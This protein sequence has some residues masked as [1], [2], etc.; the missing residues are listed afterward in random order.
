M[1]AEDK[2]SGADKIGGS[3]AN[4][5]SGPQDVNQAENTDSSKDKGLDN[6]K[7]KAAIENLFKAIAEL[8]KAI[9][10][11]E[12][13]K[14]GEEGKPGGAEPGGGQGGGKPGGAQQGG[15]Q[16]TGKPGGAQEDGSQG[17]HGGGGSC[18][19]DGG[20][21]PSGTEGG[22]GAGKPSEAGGGGSKGGK[23]D[24]AGSDKK[25]GG[26]VT[27][28][29]STIDLGDGNKVQV[30]G[31]DGTLAKN[32]EGWAKEHP[33]LKAD[34]QKSAAAN[35]GTLNVTVQDLPEG[36][37]GNAPGGGESGAGGGKGSVNIDPSAKDNLFCFSHEVKHLFGY[38]HNNKQ[39][40]AEMK[41]AVEKTVEGSEMSTQNVPQ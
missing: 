33:E 40:E 38:D 19:K 27:G 12:G 15:G 36:V 18:E 13:G 17:K 5:T 9:L 25:G 10:G 37:A 24:T 32:I 41:A 39:D 16:S 31:D 7:L 6:P 8:L 21:K 34:L 4:Q 26:E 11:E 35:G 23:G 1:A 22:G 28:S 3:K 29:G 14:P 2:V 30:H 20:S